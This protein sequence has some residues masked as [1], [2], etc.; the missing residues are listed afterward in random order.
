MSTVDLRP[1]GSGESPWGGW[2]RSASLAGILV[3][4]LVLAFFYVAGDDEPDL[5]PPVSPTTVA[6][7]T[8]P[9]TPGDARKGL[10]YLA[11]GDSLSRG[12]QPD[13]AKT[14]KNG[15][16]RILLKNLR[17]QVK[18]APVL[19]EAGCGGATTESMIVGGKA[20]APDA[21][22]PYA[23]ENRSSS[24]LLW[25]VDQLR[26]RKDLPTLVT[27]T[28]GGNDI[29]SCVDPSAEKVDACLAEAAP[30]LKANWTTIARRLRAVAGP[31]TVL[32]VMTTYD[33]VLGYLR[34]S[35]GKDGQAAKAF[36][37]QVVRRINPIMRRVFTKYDW[38]IA[39]LAFAMHENGQIENGNARAVAAVCSLTWACGNFDVHLNDQ[40]YAVAADVLEAS[41]I[42]PVLAATGASSAGG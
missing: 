21:P 26:L 17:P 30:R 4:C 31:K 12:V 19:V 24:Q 5:Q 42:D 35:G 2:R 28:I 18:P 34:I 11:L 36:H 9:T 39:D 37:R 29:T 16:P 13:G 10:V 25:A 41:V 40:G 15:Y 7:G 33:P 14:L 3:A 38:K 8:T 32:A 6:D 20:C 23:N 1:E 22:I 27:L